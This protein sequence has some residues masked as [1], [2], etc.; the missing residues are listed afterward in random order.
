MDVPQAQSRRTFLRQTAFGVAALWSSAL[1]PISCSQYKDVPQ[2]ILRRL[3]FLSGH[4]YLVVKA[5]AGRLI[6]KVLRTD[7]DAH[8]I[9]IALRVDKFLAAAHPEL[10]R[11]FHQLLVVFN[12]PIF[13]FLFELRFSSF[14][15]M[16]PPVQDAYLRSWMTSGIQFRRTAFQALKRLCVGLFYLDDRTWE[17]I[18]YR[19]PLVPAE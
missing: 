5:V 9:E 7:P 17:S 8:E 18:G 16:D 6:R 1:L 19:G 12:S 10:Q 13:A 14:L 15:D 4:E 2:E 3:T 11:Q